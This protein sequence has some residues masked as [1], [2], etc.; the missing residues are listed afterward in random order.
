MFLTAQ[1]ISN[2]SLQPLRVPFRPR[3]Q[4]S[5]P[6]CVPFIPP[7]FTASRLIDTRTEPLGIADEL[8]SKFPDGVLPISQWTTISTDDRYLSHIVYLFFTW[9]HTLSRVISKTVF[10]QDLKA[11]STKPGNLCSR[12]LVNSIL[13]IS[14]VCCVS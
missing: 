3:N 5:L 6:G 11:G 8:A 2:L 10:L 7:V 9:D 14:H 4:N 13:A 1:D 12:F